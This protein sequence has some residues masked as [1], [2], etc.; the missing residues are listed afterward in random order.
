MGS[1]YSGERIAEDN[2]LTDIIP[3]INKSQKKYRLGTV[4]NILLGEVGAYTC[5]MDPNPRPKLL[6]WFKTF[7]L[8]EGL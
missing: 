6:H 4:S 3:N 8:H 2:M 7:A 1:C 5:S